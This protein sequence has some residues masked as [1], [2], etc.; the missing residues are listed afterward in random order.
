MSVAESSCAKRSSSI[1][2]SSSAI[3]CSKSRNAVFIGENPG[4][5]GHCTR[6]GGAA[7]LCRLSAGQ[8]STGMGSRLRQRYQVATERQGS[9][10]EAIL[11]IVLSDTD[12]PRK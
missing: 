2:A 4:K 5:T 9:Q 11:R 12:R 3:G 1:F 6:I 10:T 7:P 8:Y